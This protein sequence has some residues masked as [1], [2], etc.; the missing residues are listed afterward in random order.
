MKRLVF[1]NRDLPR[2]HLRGQ[3]L[4]LLLTELG[5]LRFQLRGEG[6]LGSVGRRQEFGQSTQFEKP[7]DA[8]QTAVVSQHKHQM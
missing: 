8:S 4:I 5:Q 1:A 7:A 3:P 6:L 2:R